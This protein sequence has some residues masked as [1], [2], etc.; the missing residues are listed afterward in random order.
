MGIKL[1]GYLNI[2]MSEGVNYKEPERFAE[3]MRNIYKET[4]TI[5]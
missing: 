3:V 2:L 5:V 1:I 4:Y